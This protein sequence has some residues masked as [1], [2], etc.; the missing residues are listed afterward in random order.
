MPSPERASATTMSTSPEDVVS[1]AK[2][3]M[4]ISRD[5]VPNKVAVRS[6]VR[7]VMYPAMG[8]LSAKTRGRAT[9]R[10]PTCETL[11]P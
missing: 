11:Y 2:T 9:E 3:I 5:A 1:V 10:K 4:E 6:P 8:A 7:T